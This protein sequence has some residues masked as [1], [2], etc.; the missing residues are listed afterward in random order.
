M[1][2]SLETIQVFKKALGNQYKTCHCSMGIFITIFLHD[3][4]LFDAP[5]PLKV[6]TGSKT[7]L[8]LFLFIASQSVF[9]KKS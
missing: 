7:L 9:Q 8:C 1:E 5:K 4:S 3:E 6:H 2:K